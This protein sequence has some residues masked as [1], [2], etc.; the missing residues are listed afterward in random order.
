MFVLD[1]NV[2][3]ELQAGKLQQQLEAKDQQLGAKDRALE[4]AQLKIHVLEEP[5]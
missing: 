2:I 1:T 5:S 3:S 4:F